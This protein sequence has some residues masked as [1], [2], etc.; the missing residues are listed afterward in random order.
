ML[1]LKSSSRN[2]LSKGE[3][4]NFYMA[5][6]GETRASPAC[7]GQI[8]PSQAFVRPFSLLLCMKRKLEH[9]TNNSQTSFSDQCAS[10][11][12]SWFFISKVRMWVQ[13]AE[14]ICFRKKELCWNKRSLIGAFICI[15]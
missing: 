1:A 11:L 4:C 7:F 10:F 13:A 9:Y 14:H 2:L 8:A 15:R 3:F 5:L 12:V 6:V